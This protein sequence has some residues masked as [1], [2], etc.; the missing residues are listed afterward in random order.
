LTEG[1]SGVQIRRGPRQVHRRADHGRP[2][3]RHLTRFFPTGA[4][5]AFLDRLGVLLKDFGRY[6]EKMTATALEW[7]FDATRSG[8]CSLDLRSSWRRRRKACAAT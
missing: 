6:V 8:R 1:A 7:C 4:F 5:K 3:D 2:H